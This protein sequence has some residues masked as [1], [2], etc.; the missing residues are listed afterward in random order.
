MG[1]Y[2]LKADGLL[3]QGKCQGNGPRLSLAT[4]NCLLAITFKWLKGDLRP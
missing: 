4:L 1:M 3:A 2:T